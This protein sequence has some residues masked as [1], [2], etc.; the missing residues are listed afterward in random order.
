ME[1]KYFRLFKLTSRSAPHKANLKQDYAKIQTAA[2]ELKKSEKF[3]SWLI[4]ELPKVYTDILVNPA[5]RKRK[6][7]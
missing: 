3:N 4:Q 5:F 2:K 6:S 7:I 1:K